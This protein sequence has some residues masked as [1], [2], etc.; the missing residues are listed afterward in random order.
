MNF[1]LISKELRNTPRKLCF[2][3]L[4]RALPTLLTEISIFRWINHIYLLIV[5]IKSHSCHELWNRNVTNNAFIVHLIRFQNPSSKSIDALYK[6]W[7]SNTKCWNSKIKQPFIQF[8]FSNLEQSVFISIKIS[9]FVNHQ[10]GWINTISIIWKYKIG[11][12]FLGLPFSKKIFREVVSIRP[13]VL[14]VC[15]HAMHL[16]S[17]FQYQKGTREEKKELIWFKDKA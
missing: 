14:F 8:M 9:I 10:N 13:L 3:S 6:N 11:M 16:F 4:H 17:Q 15:V 1:E 7:G 5:A 12:V 2:L